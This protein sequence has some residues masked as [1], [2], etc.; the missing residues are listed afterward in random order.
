MRTRDREPGREQ[1]P[2]LQE[3]NENGIQCYGSG[4]G[5]GLSL[6]RVGRDRDKCLRER[7]GSGTEKLLPCKAL[8]QITIQTT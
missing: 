2:L 6:T 3:W 8:P 5:T 1:E 7:D 4:M